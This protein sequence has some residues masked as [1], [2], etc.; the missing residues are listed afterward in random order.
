MGNS[1]PT[2][3]QAERNGR[4]VA[5]RAFERVSEQLAD[6]RASTVPTPGQVGGRV[7][8]VIPHREPGVE[9]TMLPSDSQRTLAAVRQAAAPVK[10]RQV[11]E[12]LRVE[13]NVWSKLEPLRGRLVGLTGRGRLRKMPDG[14]FTTCL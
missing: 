3:V 5:G 11:G 10:T 2:E 9:E 7:V 4:V 8:T 6:A 13:V 14:R 1:Q 12:M